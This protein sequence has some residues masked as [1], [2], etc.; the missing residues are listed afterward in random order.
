M[1]SLVKKTRLTIQQEVNIRAD[2]AS[3][4]V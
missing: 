3:L 4:G 1:Q 2:R